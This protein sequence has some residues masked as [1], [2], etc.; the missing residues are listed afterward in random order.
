MSLDLKTV[1]YTPPQQRKKRNQMIAW[2]PEDMFMMQNM[3]AKCSGQHV[4]NNY[5]LV[6]RCGY[7]GC[8]CCSHLPMTRIPLTIVPIINPQCWIAP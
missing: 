5:Y 7:S 3:Q 6:V 1:R 2:S 4:K 8:T